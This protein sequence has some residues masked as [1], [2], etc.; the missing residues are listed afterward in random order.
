[1]FFI[2]NL[3]NII[4]IVVKVRL[5]DEV[6]KEDLEKISPDT[7]TIL[8]LDQDTVKVSISWYRHNP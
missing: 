3:W 4:N 6:R 8:K 1:M 7:D 2:S 5:E